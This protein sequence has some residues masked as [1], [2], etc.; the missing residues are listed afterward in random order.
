MYLSVL[1]VLSTAVVSPVWGF[2]DA[3]LVGRDVELQDK[4]DF[5]LVGG[6]TSALVIANRLTERSSSGFNRPRNDCSMLIRYL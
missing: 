6:G 1:A 5:V 2:R 3:L 4:Y